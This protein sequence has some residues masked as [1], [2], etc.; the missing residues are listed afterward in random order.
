MFK[1]KT[2]GQYLDWDT[3][4]PHNERPRM[5]LFQEGLGA[6]GVKV[7]SWFCPPRIH[8]DADLVSATSTSRVGRAPNT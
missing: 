3:V 4:V 5:E 7:E 6:G 1:C 2:P 8:Y